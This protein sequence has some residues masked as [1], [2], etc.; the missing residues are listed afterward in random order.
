[1]TG[2]GGPLN[3]TLSTGL[4]M[5]KQGFRWWTMGYAA[6][7]AV[8]LG[9]VIFGFSAVQFAIEKRRNA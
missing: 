6:A 5:Y 9:V 8:I 3:A 1:M 7:I 2:G 4:L